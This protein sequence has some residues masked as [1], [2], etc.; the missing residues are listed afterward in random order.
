M[1]VERWKGGVKDEEMDCL[2]SAGGAA[3]GDQTVI[4][5]R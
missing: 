5:H 1:R 4:L 2:F 3:A